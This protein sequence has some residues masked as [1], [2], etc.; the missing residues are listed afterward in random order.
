MNFGFIIPIC[1]NNNI[2]FNQ[3]QRCIKSIRDFYKDI[4]IILIDDSNIEYTN[5]IK[6][7][8]KYDNNI[9]IKESLIKGSS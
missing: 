7:F 3:L 5:Q 6:K 1:I 8:F 4:K 9:F 2:H